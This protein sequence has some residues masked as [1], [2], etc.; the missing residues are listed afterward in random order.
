MD[1]KWSICP[2][3]RIFRKILLISWPLSLCKVL[4]KFSQLIQCYDDVAFFGLIWLIY[5]NENFSFWK[6]VH[7]CLSTC[8]KSKSDINLLRKYLTK[9]YWNLIHQESFW[10]I[11]GESD[12][13]QGCSFQWMSVNH[14]KFCLT[15]IPDKTNDMIFLKIPKTLFLS[16]VWPCLVIFDW[17]GIFSKKIRLSHKTIYKLLTPC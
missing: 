2:K 15:Q 16:H 7:S 9:E 6:S 13:S 5:P 12:F 11:T 17:R 4:I 3:Q 14:K 10:A 1:P 8:Q